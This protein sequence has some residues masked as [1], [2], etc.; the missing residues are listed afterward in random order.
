MALI[1]VLGACSTPSSAST[2]PAAASTSAAGRLCPDGEA[3]GQGLSNFGAFIGTWQ[4]EHHLDAQHPGAYALEGAQGWVDVRCNTSGF[5]ISEELHPLHQTPAGLAL[6]LAL[7]D[8]P[9]DSRKIYD[10]SHRGCRT[11]QYQSDTLAHQLGAADR[12]GHVGF[13]FVSDG[14]TYN[15]VSV[16]VIYLDTL[17][18][19][20]ADTR[21]C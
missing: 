2:S 6:R 10:H 12:D 20:G 11:L 15:P 19:L 14:P 16:S 3:S 13:T 18:V 1:G 8:I 4:A 9:A 21:P 17:D 7:S 5:V